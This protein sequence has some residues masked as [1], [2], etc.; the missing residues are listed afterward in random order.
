MRYYSIILLVCLLTGCGKSPLF[1]KV[2]KTA[3]EISGNILLSEN[4]PMKNIEF[5]L[6]W[7]TPPSLE[8][9]GVFEIELKEPLAPNLS[10][11]AF[12]WM[13]EMGH[14]SSPIEVIKSSDLNYVF[15]EVAFIMPGLWVLHVEILENNKVVDKW[16]K[17]IVL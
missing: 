13:P 1:N 12:I 6:N 2:T 17:S 3:G 16:Q 5:S 7:K 14:G 11:N 4:F 15:S 10:I 9:L 8:E